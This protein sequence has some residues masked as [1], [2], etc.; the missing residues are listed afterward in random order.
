MP[1]VEYEWI[2][3]EARKRLIFDAQEVFVQ[4]FVEGILA[5]GYDSSKAVLAAGPANPHDHE[6]Y[7][8]RLRENVPNVDST[9][10]FYSLPLA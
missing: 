2:A 3:V 6:G 4:L 1:Y 5:P 8:H 10:L 7:F 9:V